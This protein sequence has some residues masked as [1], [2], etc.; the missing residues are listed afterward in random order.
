M[1]V[2]QKIAENWILTGHEL[3]RLGFWWCRHTPK[4]G[5]SDFG[6]EP[7]SFRTFIM[8]IHQHHRFTGA[9]PVLLRKEVR[10]RN[11]SNQ[12]LQKPNC[13][14][15]HVAGLDMLKTE[16]R[17]E[18]FAQRTSVAKTPWML[19]VQSD[20]IHPNLQKLIKNAVSCQKD[21]WMNMGALQHGRCQVQKKQNWIH[22]QTLQVATSDKTEIQLL[23]SANSAFAAEADQHLSLDQASLSLDDFA[24]QSTWYDEGCIEVNRSYS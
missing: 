14:H 3:W 20:L 7:K 4:K 10:A 19:Q 8:Q 1:V 23:A 16:L 18:L 6:S 13:F 21:T 24:H 5:S 9:S 22:Q 15:H 2:E 17:V 12:N 11:Y